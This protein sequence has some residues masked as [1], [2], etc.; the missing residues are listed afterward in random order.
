V[1]RID[2]SAARQLFGGLTFVFSG[3]NLLGAQ[4]DEPDNITVVPG[5]TISAGVQA[6][7]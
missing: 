1:T 7:F 2:A 5:R 4:R 6:K 3:R